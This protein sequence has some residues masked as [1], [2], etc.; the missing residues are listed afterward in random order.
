MLNLF[1]VN[2][3]DQYLTRALKGLENFCF[4]FRTPFLIWLAVFTAGMGYFALQLRM[5]AG[6]EK[7]MPTGHEYIETFQKYR[8]DVLGANRLNVVVK[9]KNGTIWTQAGLQR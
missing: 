3:V 6:F 5:E 8:N 2:D 1:S 4:R 9:A 7:Q